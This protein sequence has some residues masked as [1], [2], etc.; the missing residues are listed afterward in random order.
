MATKTRIYLGE[1]EGKKY[2]VDTSSVGQA[3]TTIAKR[4]VTVRLA[5]PSEIVQLMRAKSAEYIHATDDG[6]TD[7]EDVTGAPTGDA[8]QAPPADEPPLKFG[9]AQ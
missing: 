3:R 9:S 1:C 2:L 7:V 4:H 8:P 5:K 6:Q